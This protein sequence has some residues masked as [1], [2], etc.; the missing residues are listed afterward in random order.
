MKQLTKI[1]RLR[2]SD[3][4]MSALNKLSEY[5]VNVP[6]FIRSAIH[7]KILREWTAIKEE[8]ERIILPF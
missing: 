4:Q 3:K 1:Y 8:K 2:L 6:N 7:E 5:N